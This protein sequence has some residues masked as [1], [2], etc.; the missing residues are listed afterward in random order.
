MS[1]ICVWTYFR[2]VA[3]D[4]CTCASAELCIQI[5][6]SETKISI[7]RDDD[8]RANKYVSSSSSWK[9]FNLCARL[10]TIVMQVYNA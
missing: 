4:N 6:M 7:A 9:H 1:A 2:W 10:I 3:S 5:V 8:G